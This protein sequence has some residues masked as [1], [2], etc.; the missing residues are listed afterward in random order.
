V[1]VTYLQL[2]RGSAE[3]ARDV[4]RLLGLATLAA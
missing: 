1:P 4:R 3:V 2:T